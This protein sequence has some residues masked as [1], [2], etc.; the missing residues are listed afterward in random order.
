MMELFEERKNNIYDFY[1]AGRFV[2]RKSERKNKHYTFSNNINLEKIFQKEDNNIEITQ[3]FFENV[4]LIN[5]VF[6]HK[7]NIDLVKQS[8]EGILND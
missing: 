2:T 8:F 5:R 4:F 3:E 7:K 6:Y 1:K